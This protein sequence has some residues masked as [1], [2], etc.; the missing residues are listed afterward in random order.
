MITLLFE[1]AVGMRP[2]SIVLAR[3]KFTRSSLS[4]ESE[5]RP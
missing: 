3:A 4:F 1:L 2:W 5:V